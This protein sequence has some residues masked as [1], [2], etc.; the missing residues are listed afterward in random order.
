MKLFTSRFSNKD[1]R[2]RPD[3]VKVCIAVGKPRW[4]VGYE[5]T[6]CRWLAPFG[7]R[8]LKGEHFK[9]AYV[10]KLDKLGL[11]AIR[12]E[13]EMIS[14]AHGDKDLVLLCYE[15]LRKPG[16][17]CHRAMFAEWWLRQ[18]GDLVLELDTDMGPA[19]PAEQ[20]G[21]C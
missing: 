5:W 10:A 16:L 4:P 21:L 1:L 8:K 17:T 12:Q 18:T 11:K 3:L 2:A 7:L 6:T 13:L 20:M 19:P 14:E 9:S 15:D